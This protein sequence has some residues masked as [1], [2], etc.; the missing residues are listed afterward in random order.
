MV[1]SSSIFIFVFLPIVLTLYYI[2]HNLKFRNLLLLIVSL[3]FY[4]IGEYE[5]LYLLL[6][7]IAVN[8]L[9]AIGIENAEVIQKRKVLLTIDI[10]FN[11][12]MLFIFKYLGFSIQIIDRL[13]HASFP[14]IHLALPLG[15]SFFTF[16]AMSYVI[17]VYRGEE[18][19]QRNP[20]NAG[21]YIVLFPQLIA[22]PIVRYKKIAVELID[23]HTT[24]EDFEDG[25]KRFIIGFSKKIIL[26]NNLS[27]LAVNAFSQIE[28]VELSILYA[29]LGALAFTF[30]I[31]FDFSGYS[32]MAI[33]LGK[34]FGFHF[35]ENFIY[36]YIS[37]SVTDFWRRWHISLGQWFRD[38]V[39][40]PLGGSRVPLWR[41]ILNLL[42]VWGLTGLWHGA[43]YH[44]VAWGLLYFVLLTFE[45]FVL[46]PEHS[47]NRIFIAIYRVFTFICVTLGWVLFNATS[48]HEA[49][50]YIAC[51]FGLY[52]NQLYDKA[53]I[54]QFHEYKW[55]LFLSVICATPIFKRTIERCNAHKM[56][57]TVIEVIT[58][59][60]YL[61]I[62]LLAM[63][64]L[65]LGAYNP[66]LYFNF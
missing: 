51:M 25:V 36:P 65:L 58:P 43:S 37:R 34:M 60:G 49:F 18:K 19:A 28:N 16:Q 2:G 26:A 21:L 42:I 59:F 1:F 63:S 40:I 8:Y 24:W 23:R 5:H 64:F 3:L 7:S 50:R 46:H 54:F 57:Q 66:F 11:L 29:W 27:V 39:Y 4:A 53:S 52:G 30:Q 62:L 61:L 12:G 14:E 15:I 44:F 33:G 35:D 13:F 56:M 47:T 20:V 6:L 10:I 41:H 31:L 45:K 48:F 38:Y 55:Y 32:D 17:D 9:L 22:G